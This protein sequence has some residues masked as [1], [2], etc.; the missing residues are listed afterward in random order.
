MLTN[1]INK[2]TLLLLMSASVQVM[3]LPDDRNKP[4][5]VSADS[6]TRN[7]QSG[8]TLYKGRVELAQG[9]MQITGNIVEIRQN[10]SGLRAIVAKG[11]PAKYQQKP[12]PGEEITYAYGQRLEYNINTQ[13]LTITGQAKVTQG[14]DTFSGNKIVY[15][16]RKSIVD[17]FSDNS[18]NG[19]RVKMVIQPKPAEPETESETETESISTPEAEQPTETGQEQ[20]Q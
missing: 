10:D 6:A 15:D 19:E 16:M 12:A 7:D 14:S 11:K 5:H 2:L 13:K 17:A 8:I 3:A 20:P 4:I 9:S 18:L 1:T